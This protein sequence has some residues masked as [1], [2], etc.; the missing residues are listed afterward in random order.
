SLFPSP[1]SPLL[2]CSPSPS[3]RSPFY[4]SPTAMPRSN[5]VE[6]KRQKRWEEKNAKREEKKEDKDEGI[7][8]WIKAFFRYIFNDCTPL[9]IL[10]SL[11][12]F[13]VIYF[14]SGNYQVNFPISPRP[15]LCIPPSQSVH[16]PSFVDR[17]DFLP[18]NESILHNR[19]LLREYRSQFENGM[20][21]PTAGKKFSRPSEEKVRSSI[22]ALID[23]QLSLSLRSHDD[24]IRELMFTFLNEV[25]KCALCIHPISTDY[26]TLFPLSF[27]TKAKFVRPS[28]EIPFGR[29]RRPIE[30][31]EAAH[32]TSQLFAWLGGEFHGEALLTAHRFSLRDPSLHDAI[33]GFMMKFNRTTGTINHPELLNLVFSARY[34]EQ[35]KATHN[36]MMRRFEV[37]TECKPQFETTWVDYIRYAPESTSNSR[38]NCEWT[39]NYGSPQGWFTWMFR[40]MNRSSGSRL[41]KSTIFTFSATSIYFAPNLNL[42]QSIPFPRYIIVN[43]VL[44]ALT[45][46]INDYRYG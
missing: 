26:S 45:Y 36:E 31:I 9:L 6:E 27:C 14:D 2:S 5:A 25:H 28:N 24:Q 35:L 7:I 10:V 12:S 42:R 20:L 21:I 41:V 32:M 44:I 11:Q 46:K 30:L 33:Q 16:G 3:P 39:L 15:A 19:A 17:R 23:F 4:V 40:I 37:L 22:R 18:C 29:D 34:H 1:S 8:G 38:H 13:V 43:C